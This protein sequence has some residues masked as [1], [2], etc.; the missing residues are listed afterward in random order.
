MADFRELSDEQLISL[1]RTGDRDAVEYLMDKYKDLVRK[2]ARTLYLIGGD[3]DDLIQEGMIGLYK[4]IRDYQQD[5]ESSFYHFAEL[6]IARQIYTAVKNSN[7]QKN[8]P[9]NNYVSFDSPEY[10]ESGKNGEMQRNLE[11]VKKISNPEQFVLDKE[12][13]SMLEYEL[14]RRLSEFEKQVLNLYIQ[15]FS[16]IR[17][18]EMLGREEKAIDNALS[19]V[20]NKLNDVLKEMSQYN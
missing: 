2:R 19:R 20:R 11:F 14:V 8:R 10:G 7:T 6:C 12:Y 5:R 18:A 17:I 1:T 16:Y 3:R 13:A 15:D 4:A 9:L